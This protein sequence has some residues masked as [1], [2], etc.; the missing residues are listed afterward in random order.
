VSNYGR[1]RPWA[2]KRVVPFSR[3][4]RHRLTPMDTDQSQ[5]VFDCGIPSILYVNLCLS[6]AKEKVLAGWDLPNVARAS[7]P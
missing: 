4:L 1:R 3:V 2:K 5:I 7:G 6:V